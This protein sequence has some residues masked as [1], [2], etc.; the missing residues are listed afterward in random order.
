MRQILS[1]IVLALLGCSCASKRIVL[2]EK[3][4]F[5]LFD[6][7]GHRGTRGLMP[8][9]TVQAMYKAIDLG[10]TTI[11]MDCNISKDSL[12]ILSHNNALNPLHTLDLDGSVLK[13]QTDYSFFQMPYSQ[14][15]RYDVGTKFYEKFPQQRKMEAHIP[16]LADLIDSVQNYL[17][18]SGKPQVFYNIETKSMGFVNDGKL[19]PS[20]DIFVD[21]LMRVVM[22]KKVTPWVI[23][24]SSDVRTLQ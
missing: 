17:K 7:E 14:I 12:V 18:T 4:P 19:H 1:V 16:L 11:E 5:P 20:P 8:E 21:L 6:R 2:K 22:T 15:K 3:A 13:D 9:N 24:Q 23:I 10:V